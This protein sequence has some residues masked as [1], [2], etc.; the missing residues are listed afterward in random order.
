[1]NL[2]T[3]KN[4]SL[5]FTLYTLGIVF[6]FGLGVNITFFRQRYGSEMRA[7][8][9]APKNIPNMLGNNSMTNENTTQTHFGRRQQFQKPMIDEISYSQE[10]WDELQDSTSF[11]VSNIASIEDQDVLF[12]RVNDTIRISNITRM[13]DAQRS[14]IITF[15]FLLLIFAFL[16]YILSIFFVKTSL[17]HV[18][19]LVEYVKNLDINTLHQPVPLS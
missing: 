17:R 14:M 18:H 1:M 7:L 6:F 3:S 15:F 13:I 5:K 16:T 12:V 4:I 8:Q 19:Q 11:L 2:T 9:I 10:V